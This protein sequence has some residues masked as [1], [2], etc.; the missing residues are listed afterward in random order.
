MYVV[1]NVFQNFTKE[2]NSERI[3]YANLYLL[4]GKH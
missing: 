3:D 4:F 2:G 1:S